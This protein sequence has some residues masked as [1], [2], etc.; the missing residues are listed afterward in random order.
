MY[1]FE[2]NAKQNWDT[3]CFYE[4]A[5]TPEECDLILE[6]GKSIE[7]VNAMTADS[8]KSKDYRKARVSWISWNQENDWIFS[9]LAMLTKDANNFRFRFNISGFTEKLQ[10]TQY[11]EKDDHFVWH[12]DVG[13]GIPSTR[14]LSISIQLSDPLE[15][16]GCELQFFDMPEK[17]VPKTKGT[18]IVFPSYEVHK[19]TPLISGERFSLVAWVAG[20][21]FA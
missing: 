4:K 20:P 9:R 10:L 1:I 11:T 8:D 19:V 6:L 21:P 14:K 15:Y 16:E 2:Q 13:S 18:A 7:S 5:F 17:Q 12:K 3:Y